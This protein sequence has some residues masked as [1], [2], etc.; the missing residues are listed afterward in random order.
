MNF[1][2]LLIQEA[3]RLALLPPDPEEVARQAYQNVVRK[4]S[5]QASGRNLWD[6]FHGGIK[7][8]VEEHLRSTIRSK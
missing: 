8:E 6:E 5:D 2:E 3:T 4:V 7:E 1:K